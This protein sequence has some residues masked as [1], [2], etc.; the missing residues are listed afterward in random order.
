MVTISNI[1]TWH[2]G[3]L[4]SDSGDVLVIAHYPE[5]MAESINR[6]DEIILRLGACITH[7]NLIE[8]GIVRISEEDRFD[9]RIANTYMLHTILFLVAG[10]VN[11]RYDYCPEE[12]MAPEAK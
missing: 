3:K 11:Q 2:L 10:Y 6:C 7:K 1:E 12:K 4:S 5:L 9:I 8:H